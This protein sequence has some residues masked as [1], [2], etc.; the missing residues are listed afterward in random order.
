MEAQ[1][2]TIEKQHGR[3]EDRKLWAL[4]VTPEQIGF[5]AAEQIVRIE[6]SRLHVKLGKDSQETVFGILSIT[7]LPDVAQNADNLLFVSREQWGIENCNHYV[8]DRSYD[9]DRCQVR[10]ANSAHILATLRSM[11]TFIARLE[12]HNPRTARDRG[13]P[14]MNRYC[15]AHRFAPIR[16]IRADTALTG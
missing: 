3:V 16:W 11:A 15:N 9:E 8:R 10:N 5:C 13:V 1:A 6:R 7:P 12:L 4:S 14:A 2:Q